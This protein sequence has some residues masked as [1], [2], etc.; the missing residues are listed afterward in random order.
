M[1]AHARLGR[2]V[3]LAFQGVAQHCIFLGRYKASEV[4]SDQT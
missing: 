4:M 3:F 2:R 1:M